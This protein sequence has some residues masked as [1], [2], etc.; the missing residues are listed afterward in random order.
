M[1]KKIPALLAAFLITICVG[2]GMLAVSGSAY[3]NKNGIPVVDSP[4]SATATAAAVSAQ[5]AQIQQLQDLVN[6]YQAREQQYQSQITDASQQ[7]NASKQQI[8][9]YQQLLMALQ[10]RGVISISADGRV[11]IP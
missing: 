11:M 5:E 4:I 10:S 7:I 8:Q 6:Q 9:Q 2:L 1:N 3:F